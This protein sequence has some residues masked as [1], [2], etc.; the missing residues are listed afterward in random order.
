[1][2]RTFDQAM[3]ERKPVE[4]QL[5]GL[6]SEIISSIEHSPPIR[7]HFTVEQGM[8]LMISKAG[9]SETLTWRA[10]AGQARRV[11]SML[12]PRDA[13]LVEAYARECDDSARAPSIEGSRV[14]TRRSVE[15]QRRDDRSFQ[16][17]VVSQIKPHEHA[18]LVGGPP[19]FLIGATLEHTRCWA[20]YRADRSGSTADS[21]QGSAT[22]WELLFETAA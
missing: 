18:A 5:D 14:D 4:N 22:I 12:S 3:D 9:L 20:R 21:N 6:D 16:P 13:A 2:A 19:F 1:M 7:Q 8:I 17:K 10:R 11:A 15:I